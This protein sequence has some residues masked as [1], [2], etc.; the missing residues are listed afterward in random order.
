MDNSAFNR[1]RRAAGLWLRLSKSARTANNICIAWS[2]K[3][4][5]PAFLGR[6]PVPLACFVALCTAVACGVIFG[7][8]IIIGGIFVYMLCN[9]AISG[10]DDYSD[11][12]APSY[13]TEWRNGSEGT[14]IYT[15][16]EHGPGP[17]YRVD[18]EDDED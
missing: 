1:G 16:P 14:G 6:I 17:S 3:R 5:F 15:G 7:T 18:I 10:E 13:G 2:I 12:H 9:I 8:I 11:D 4:G